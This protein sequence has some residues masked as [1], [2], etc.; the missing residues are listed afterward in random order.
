MI[1]YVVD[2][3]LALNQFYNLWGRFDCHFLYISKFCSMFLV[4]TTIIEVL[5]RACS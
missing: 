5:W 1:N 2:W 3:L 4:E